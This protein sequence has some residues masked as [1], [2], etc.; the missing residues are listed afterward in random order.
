MTSIFPLLAEAEHFALV[1]ALCC[2]GG[3]FVEL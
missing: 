2:N 3:A 1:E